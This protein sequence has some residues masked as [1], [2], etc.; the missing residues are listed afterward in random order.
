MWEIK[1]KEFEDEIRFLKNEVTDTRWKMFALESKVD[2]LETRMSLVLE[3]LEVLEAEK[4]EVIDLTVDE[5]EEDQGGLGGPIFL[6]PETPAPSLDLAPLDAETVE[7][8]ERMFH[9]WTSV[10]GDAET[11]GSYDPTGPWGPEF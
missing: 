10:A 8:I 7:G 1:E 6:A 9:E 11:E 3:Q 5:K 2:V 4:K